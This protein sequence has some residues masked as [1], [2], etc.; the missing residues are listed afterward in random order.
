MNVDESKQ[1]VCERISVKKNFTIFD[2]ERTR[3]Y[4]EGISVIII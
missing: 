2:K 1:E 3:V 4:E